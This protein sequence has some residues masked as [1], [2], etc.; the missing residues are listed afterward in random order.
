[1]EAALKKYKVIADSKGLSLTEFVIAWCA[2]FQKH[3]AGR[4]VCMLALDA[5][6]LFS[7]YTLGNFVAK[8][9]LHLHHRCLCVLPNADSP[10]NDCF[11]L[12][13]RLF[14]QVQHHRVHTLFT[15]SRMIRHHESL[16]LQ[17]IFG[18][19]ASVAQCTLPTAE[20]KAFTGSAHGSGLASPCV[21]VQA[22]VWLPHVFQKQVFTTTAV[23]MNYP[24]VL[25]AS[26][27]H[28]VASR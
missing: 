20:S 19:W 14:P 2:P 24:S 15:S 26:D 16:F 22:A 4:L 9:Y 1:M 27:V 25:Y 7:Q 28:L 10:N 17:S 11:W 18:T 21:L 13:L 6:H 5:W 8:G 23:R 3:V 12:Q